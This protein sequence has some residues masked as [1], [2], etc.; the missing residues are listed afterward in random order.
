[1]RPVFAEARSLATAVMPLAID[2]LTVVDDAGYLD[3]LDTQKEV[4]DAIKE[5]LRDL[6]S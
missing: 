4:P 1:M 6:W 3:A 5:G 2:A